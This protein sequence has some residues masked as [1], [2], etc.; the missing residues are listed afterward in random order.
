MLQE[1]DVAD[2]PMMELAFLKVAPRKAYT[3]A[4]PHHR[5]GSETF[6]AEVRA[7]ETEGEAGDGE[8]G[9]LEAWKA[10]GPLQRSTLSKCQAA[11]V[12]ENGGQGGD[13]EALRNWGSH[14]K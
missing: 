11:N 14:S 5:S 10:L 1:S 9:L 12:E 6:R 7:P 2:E 13:A 3:Q 8:T 4:G